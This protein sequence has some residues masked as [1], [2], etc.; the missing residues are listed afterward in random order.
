MDI[1]INSGL[2]SLIRPLTET[3]YSGLE[4]AILRDSIREPLAVWDN[5]GKFILLDGHNRKK[6]CDKHGIEYK[7]R[8]IKKVTLG[9]EELDL[10]SLDRAQIWV[11]HNQGARRNLESADWA[12]LVA[13]IMPAFSADAKRRL[14]EGQKNKPTYGGDNKGVTLGNS[15]PS[16]K[17]VKSATYDEG[18]AVVQAIESIAPSQTNKTYVQAALK[19]GGYKD[20]EFTKPEKFKKLKEDVG[21]APKKAKHKIMP[22]LIKAAKDK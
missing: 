19:E 22:A 5:G 4:A 17:P 11:A 12:L 1:T 21:A 16:V 2:K 3:E 13:E 15:L 18:K 8:V 9:G 10:D 7:T 6:I 14:E 20:G